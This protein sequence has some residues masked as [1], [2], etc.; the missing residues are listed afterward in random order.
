MNTRTIVS[1][2]VTLAGLLFAQPSFAQNDWL[3]AKQ[4]EGIKVYVHNVEGSPLLEFC[5]EVQLKA[6]SEEVVRVLRN[7]DAYRKWMPDVVT[8]ERLK[9]TRPDF[10]LCS[11]ANQPCEA[12]YSCCGAK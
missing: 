8:S 10:A 3:L 6:R 11:K 12:L 9:A 1:P 2:A 5:G 7:A 4:A